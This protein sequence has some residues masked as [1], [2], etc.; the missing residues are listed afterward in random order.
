MVGS[1]VDRVLSLLE[2]VRKMGKGYEARCPYHE[3]DDPSL[4]VTEGDDGRVLINC[5]R[6]CDTEAVVAMLGL[7]M[8]D[9]FPSKK[10]V[11]V[12]GAASG[13]AT[14]TKFEMREADGALVAYHVRLDR[15]GEKKRVWWELP[16]GSRGLGGKKLEDLPLY[17][18]EKLSAEAGVVFVCE[19]EP[20]ADALATL[21]VPV[22]GTATGADG[23]PSHVQLAFLTGRE[24]VL[25]PDHDEPGRRHMEKVAAALHALGIS[26]RVLAWPEALAKGDAA[27][28]VRDGLGLDD[29][30]ALYAEAPYWA[31]SD[32]A[33]APPEK[34]AA[35]NDLGN[36][37][38]LLRRHGTDLL[39]CKGIG[40]YAWVGNRWVP[41]DDTAMQG[42]AIETVYAIYDEAVAADDSE[43]RASLLKWAK[44]SGSGRAISSM[45]GLA[46]SLAR[47]VVPDE[48]DA[49]PYLLGVTNGTLDLKTGRL[50]ES[51][52]GDLITR[53][54]RTAYVPDAACPVW[55]AFLERIFAG[56]QLMI[57]YVR[58]AL[59]YSL[60]G[61]TGERAMFI[62]FGVGAN[63]KSTMIEL[64]QHILGDYATATPVDTLLARKDKGIP[65]D[66]ARLKSAR[67]VSA[68]ESERGHKLA[69]GVVKQMTGGD[70]VSA[71]FLNKEWFDFIPQLKLWLATNHRPEVDAGGKAV[72]VRIRLIPFE[73]E[74]PQEE[75]DKEL[76]E[77]LRAEAEGILAWM[78]G[79]CLEWQRMGL[80][81]PEKIVAAN[82]EY[83]EAEDVLGA[84]I[85]DSCVVQ[86]HVWEGSGELYASFKD[87]AER[88]GEERLSHRAFTQQLSERRGIK[89]GRQGGTGVRGFSGIK[90]LTGSKGK[91]K[92][93]DGLGG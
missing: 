75:W 31:P 33:A 45:V 55:L 65:N 43:Q 61:D 18:I 32:A 13:P 28:F 22:V 90:L 63:G 29:L 16:D 39:W 77:K 60:T 25:W 50:R 52:R 56:D 54:C 74:I 14:K 4:S 37:E 59:G 73:V 67:F 83:A 27:D 72:W 15:P 78:V 79:G 51:D 71:R 91:G 23:C 81:E 80:K 19:G 36:A 87:W 35:Q 62:P 66:V 38:R 5:F 68:V 76:K 1:P 89:K 84:W 58:R 93:E 42:R 24:V 3:D 86:P 11:A 7:T 85:D 9:L 47:S 70:T 30:R 49:D 40:W 20:A 21:G 44:S 57:A 48:L 64:T 92:Q 6:G 69:Q 82:Q 8:R 17:R 12:N 41:A 88:H 46:R 26:A 10:P 34:P 53:S 2:G